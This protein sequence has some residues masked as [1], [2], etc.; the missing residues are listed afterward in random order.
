MNAESHVTGQLDRLGLRPA[1]GDTELA[2]GI[3]LIECGGHGDLDGPRTRAS[4]RKLT[5]IEGVA[6]V[7]HNHDAEQWRTSG[8]RR[9]GTP[10]SYRLSL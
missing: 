5:N 10:D 8:T 3:T 6:L 4:Q 2:P 7:V 1:D 9:P